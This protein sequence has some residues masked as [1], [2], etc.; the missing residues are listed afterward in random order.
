LHSIAGLQK[1][2][3]LLQRVALAELAPAGMYQ[4]AGSKQRMIGELDYAPGNW[5]K[6][7][8]VIARP[9]HDAPSA[10]PR[11]IVTNLKGRPKAL[12]K[13]MSCAR[14][15][16]ENRIEEAQLDLIG[17]R[18]SCLSFRPVNYVCYWPHSPAP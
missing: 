6:R 9:E 3:A 4:A 2:S 14:C 13:Y 1:N 10:N 11:F 17:L 8:R 16:S 18:A 5:D 15:E 7:R 12:Y